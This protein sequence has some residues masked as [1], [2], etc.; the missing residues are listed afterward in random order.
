MNTSSL[1]GLLGLVLV[2]LLF[3]SWIG[4]RPRGAQFT[5]L[6][7][8]GEGFQPARKTFLADAALSTRYLLVKQGTDAAHVAVC[9]AADFPLGIATDE[10]AAAEDGVNVDLLGIQ[11]EG[12]ILV[13]AGA[14][15]AGT[16]VYTAASGKVQAEPTEAGTYWRVGR[17]L[18]AVGGADLHVEVVPLDPIKIVV[19]AAFGNA[20]GEISALTSSSTTTQAEFNALRDKCEELADDLRALGAACATP[21]LVKVLSA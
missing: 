13:S 5:P 18:S 12:K 2:A 15:T 11:D 4:S 3:T 1:L 17:A 19:I 14:I 21:A 10:P 7:N 20:N 16:Y 6:A 8:I 9:G